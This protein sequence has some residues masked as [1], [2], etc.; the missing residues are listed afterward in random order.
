M[1]VGGRLRRDFRGDIIVFGVD[2]R[3]ERRQACDGAT[4]PAMR[5]YSIA[6]GPERFLASLRIIMMLR[7]LFVLSLALL[8]GA[9]RLSP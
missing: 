8:I 1:S 6:V 2:R 4:R 5:L 3:A 7:L 9:W